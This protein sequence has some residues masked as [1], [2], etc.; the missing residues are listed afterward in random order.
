M[1]RPGSTRL[2]RSGGTPAKTPDTREGGRA[3]RPLPGHRVSP[4]SPIPRLRLSAESDQGQATR[5]AQRRPRGD[6]SDSPH[7][8]PR[9]GPQR[10]S[11]RSE[12]NQDGV[13]PSLGGAPATSPPTGS[14]VEQDESLARPRGL[15]TVRACRWAIGQLRR[16]HASVAGL[17]RQLGMT[18]RTVWTSIA[19][20][21][22]AAAADP[23][24]FEGVSTLG[25]TSTCGT[26]CPPSPSRTAVAARRS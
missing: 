21:L 13:H 25:W 11:R 22:A 9:P 2:D 19:P 8:T 5:R 7:A 6:Q 4:H 1:L 3:S 12:D 16:E 10:E 17:A 20:V 15:L 23:A 18:W 14:F 24:R 26:T